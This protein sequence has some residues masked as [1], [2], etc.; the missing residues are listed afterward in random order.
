MKNDFVRG[1]EAEPRECGREV[2]AG[3]G[4]G[5]SDPQVE[6]N[7]WNRLSESLKFVRP[8]HSL[9]LLQGMRSV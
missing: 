7:I 9:D 2:A 3:F 1:N 4:L 6:V 8:N 5:L